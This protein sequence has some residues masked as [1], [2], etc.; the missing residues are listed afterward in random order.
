[1]RA[2]DANLPPLI[3][4][5]LEPQRYPG[6]VSRVELVQT[7]ISWVLL[8]GDYAYKIKK[9]VKLSF[10]D[11]STLA[12]RQM[13]CEDELRLNRRFAPE[14][15]QGVVGIFNTPQD[16]LWQGSGVPIEVAVKM[17]RFDESARLDHVCERGELGSA[18]LSSLA[19]AVAVFHDA[20]AATPPAAHLGSPTL[21]AQQ[22]LDNFT[23]LLRCPLDAGL[24]TRLRVLRD[25]TQAALQQLTPLLQQRWQGGRVRECHG[26]LHLANMVL[27]NGQV[28]MFDCI[29]F[30]DELR[31][32][33]VAS[34]IAFT[35]VDLLAQG[36]PGLANWF[37][38]EVFSRSGD[39]EA[40]RV[41]RF[42]AV[43]RALVRAKVQALR[44]LQTG[45]DASGVEAYVALAQ[46]LASV[47][48]V[49]LLITHG[50][51]ACGKTVASDALLQADTQ[52]NTLRL[53]SDVQR[54]RLFGLAPLAH[55]GAG[56]RQGI[57]APDAHARTY[58]HLREQ[59]AM[60]LRAGWSVVVDATFLRHAER[61]A[62]RALAQ[63]L[64][65]GF[66]ILAPQASPAQLRERIA[67]RQALGRDAS[68]ATL[69]VLAQQMQ[70]L[71]PLTADE[72][73]CVLG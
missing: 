42:Y 37:V 24:Q 44:W 70:D 13:Y 17:R 73:A 32:I 69:E 40:A 5:L 33:D 50:L 9:P 41:L 47:P 67:V 15:Y 52:A 58:A 31:W 65:V 22:A 3:Q 59:A 72:L 34:D 61:A 54:K 2:M 60:L 48:P 19:D 4:A 35:Y 20:A 55:S 49:R 68:E 7:H 6:H 56:L 1:M 8:A 12:L 16:P 26:D 28:Q 64:G 25:W 14:L 30:S 18:H 51:A 62:F 11:F 66:G 10:L 63:E 45:G 39:Y 29:E 43:Y 23:D 53:R 46:R 36:K 71:E 27:I 21:V 57:Y 38:N